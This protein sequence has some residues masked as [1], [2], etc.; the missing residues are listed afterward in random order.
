MYPLCTLCNFWFVVS[1]INADLSLSEVEIALDDLRILQPILTA[2][3]AA[4]DKVG[5]IG[6]HIA[7][8]GCVCANDHI[9]QPGLTSKKQSSSDRHNCRVCTPR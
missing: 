1:V 3:A 6:G 2:L 9:L 8:W 5:S 4:I 7:V